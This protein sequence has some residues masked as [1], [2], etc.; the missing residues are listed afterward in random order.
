M[1][2][3]LPSPKQNKKVKRV[4]RGIGSGVGGHTTGRGTKGQKSRSGY[5]RPTPDFE[6]GQN[7]IS[8]RTP[9]LKGFKR[10]YFK[11]RVRNINLKLSEVEA[12][13]TEKDTINS[14]YLKKNGFVSNV[15]HKKPLVKVLFDKEIKKSLAFEGVKLSKKAQEAVEKAKGSVK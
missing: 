2:N 13:A 3:T 4:G 1:I 12:I 8:R 7:P 5:K 14:E 9:K 6:G 10:A 15:S 11:S